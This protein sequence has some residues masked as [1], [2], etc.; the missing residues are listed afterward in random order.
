MAATFAQ[1]AANFNPAYAIISRAGMKRLRVGDENHSIPDA[2]ASV[3][4]FWLASGE[5]FPQNFPARA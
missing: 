1:T 4:T 2:I 3:G 5:I